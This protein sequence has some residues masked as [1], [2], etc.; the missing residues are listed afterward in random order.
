MKRLAIFGALVL[1]AVTPV[2]STR[3]APM[4]TSLEGVILTVVTTPRT[5][6][7]VPVEVPADLW[8]DVTRRA[9]TIDRAGID[10]AF[11]P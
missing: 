6:L 11:R 3:P 9:E 1:L 2:P 5:G 8:P 10:K 7:V 4:P